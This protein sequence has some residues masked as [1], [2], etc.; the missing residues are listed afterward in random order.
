MSNNVESFELFCVE[1]C[2]RVV[3]NVVEMEV[4]RVVTAAASSQ[5]N[6]RAVSAKPR[7]RDWTTAR[8]LKSNT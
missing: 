6:T 7:K 2:G 8:A 5:Q 3:T 1:I 4:V